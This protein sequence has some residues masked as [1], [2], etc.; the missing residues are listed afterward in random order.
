[1]PT[2]PW[3]SWVVLAGVAGLAELHFPGGYL[4]WIAL[5]AAITAAI[6]FAWRSSFEAQ[7]ITFALA[8]ALS[9]GLGYF[10]YRH[11][12][13]RPSGHAILNQ[14]DR[15]MIGAHGVVSTALVGGRGKVRLGD[16]VWQAQGPDLPE[17]TPVVVT[18]TKNSWVVVE[19]AARS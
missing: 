12:H 11:Y 8:S 17:G 2:F 4:V 15:A 13:R 9:C 6:E 14:R 7:V 19:P 16:V 10:V 5:G 1:M 18:A 3:W